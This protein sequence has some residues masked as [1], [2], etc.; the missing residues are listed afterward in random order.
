MG[1]RRHHQRII[2]PLLAL[3]L[4]ISMTG[5]CA[6]QTT[7]NNAD[8]ST[9]GTRPVP[10]ITGERLP[11]AS[12][13]KGEGWFI[14]DGE[15]IPGPYVVTITDSTI[16][17]NGILVV[18]KPEP[19]ET[20]IVVDPKATAQHNLL[21]EMRDS[22]FVWIDRVGIETAR[23]N[24]VDF[25]LTQPIVASACLVP[26][27]QMKL[28]FRDKKHEEYISLQRPPEHLESKE[29]RLQENVEKLGRLIERD[30]TSGTLVL[31]QQGGGG[32]WAILHPRSQKIIKQLKEIAE[33]EF[34]REKRLSAIREIIPRMEYAAPLADRFMQDSN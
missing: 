22:F 24:C 28:Q 7:E 10:E 17:V 13:Y 9:V 14:L 23:D 27:A 2:P 33:S 16:A 8:D 25:M 29:Q 34:N 19:P 30:L 26:V 5:I 20:T 15:L 6:A 18:S 31:M 1:R 32:Y 21:N 12:K 3:F 11:S 4:V